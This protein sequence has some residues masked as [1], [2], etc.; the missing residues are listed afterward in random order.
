MRGTIFIILFLCHT[1]SLGA[2]DSRAEETVWQDTTVYDSVDIHAVFP[3]GESSLLDYIR[4]NFVV[5]SRCVD[6]HIPCGYHLLQFV[7]DTKGKINDVK[8]L[9]GCNACPEWNAEMVRV[10]TASPRWI[11]AQNKGRFVNS[12]RQIKLNLCSS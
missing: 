12:W 6:D 9:S 7:V 10:I 2:Q 8:L 5:P 11:P 1:A 3:G 4:E